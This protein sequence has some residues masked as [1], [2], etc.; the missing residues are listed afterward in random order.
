M[1]VNVQ[2]SYLRMQANAPTD[3]LELPQ[4]QMAEFQELSA[5]SVKPSYYIC[6]NSYPKAYVP[7]KPCTSPLTSQE[8]AAILALFLS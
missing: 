6:P 1:T 5:R 2:E 7:W 8:V 4:F 3:D